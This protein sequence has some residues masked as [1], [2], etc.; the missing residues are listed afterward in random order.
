MLMILK[1]IVKIS[2][3]NGMNVIKKIE[4]FAYCYWIIMGN[5]FVTDS[6]LNVEIAVEFKNIYFRYFLFLRHKMFLILAPLGTFYL[7]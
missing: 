3:R 2:W 4:Y 1:I 7:F 5:I 6:E